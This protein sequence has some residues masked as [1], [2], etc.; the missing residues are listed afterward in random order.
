[1]VVVSGG[2]CSTSIMSERKS[3]K[4]KKREKNMDKAK[5]YADDL[6]SYHSSPLAFRQQL[7][8]MVKFPPVGQGLLFE[9]VEAKL[10][11]EATSMVNLH[12]A[13]MIS[14]EDFDQKFNLLKAFKEITNDILARFVKLSNNNKVN[15][16]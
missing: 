9:A 14:K 11:A 2:H 15:R 4:Q 10:L 3:N 13:G 7:A 12:E 1:M 5:R 6:V 16:R 8:Q